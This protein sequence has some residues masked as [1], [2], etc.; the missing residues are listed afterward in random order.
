MPGSISQLQMLYVPEEDRILFRV[1]TSE[2]QQFRFWLTR[3]YSLLLLKVLKEH[4]ATDPDVSMQDSR[5]AKQAVQSFKREQAMTS[6][7][8]DEAFSEDAN[9]LPLGEE[10]PVAFK[11]S[12]NSSGGS[13]SV[14]IEPREGQGISMAI[15]RNI[16]VSLT[17]LLVNAAGQGDWGLAAAVQNSINASQNN[18]VIN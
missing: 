8:F 12:Y 9:E 7:N 6:A 18:I 15:D 3:R 11:L 2:R 16:N 5:E 13:L 10:I 17:A 1:N 14:T 4:Q